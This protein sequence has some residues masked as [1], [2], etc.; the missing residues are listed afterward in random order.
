M[1]TA[2]DEEIEM[3]DLDED[4]D[5]QPTDA[6]NLMKAEQIVMLIEEKCHLTFKNE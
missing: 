6:L 1:L 2:D 4:D 5:T 3:R